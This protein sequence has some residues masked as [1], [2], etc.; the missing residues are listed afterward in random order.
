M[1]KNEADYTLTFRRLCDLAGLD[2]KTD[3][4]VRSLFKNPTVFDDWAFRWRERLKKEKIGDVQR[5][6]LMREVN[7][8]YIPR[9]HLIEEV[10]N[11]AVDDKNFSPF[12]S[13]NRVLSLPYQDQTDSAK[14]AAPPRPEQVV[15]ATYCG[16]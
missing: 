4:P 10:I 14:F 12:D 8:A 7:P 1:A 3:E 13:L 11:A 2:R 6:E 9:N 5:Q 16:T 15:H